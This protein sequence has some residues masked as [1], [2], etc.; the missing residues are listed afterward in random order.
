MKHLLRA[1]KSKLGVGPGGPPVPVPNLAG[2]REL[3]WTYAAARAGRYAGPGKSVLDF[4][5]GVG[6]LSFAAASTGARVLAIDLM[7]KQFDSPWPKIEFRPADVM[8]LDENAERFD[9]VFNCST[10][11]H[12]GLSGRYNSLEAPD[13]DLDAMAKL[14][15]L[16]VPGGHMALTLPVGRDAVFKPLHRVY[17]AE[18]L[19]RLLEGY[20]VVEANYWR[21]D[22]RNV[23]LPCSEQ[24]AKAEIGSDHYYAIGCLTLRVE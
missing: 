24:E 12:V 22:A 4:G 18:R 9:L 2:D 11:E 15:R 13:G 6:V 17:G 10:I 16:L 19:P 1:I 8:S 23:W 3:E 20:E 21:K 14:K 7:P 5:C